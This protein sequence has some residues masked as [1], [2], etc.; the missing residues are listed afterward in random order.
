VTL[1]LFDDV[2]LLDLSLKPA[3]G[4]LQRLA[5]LK[6]YFSQTNYTSQLDQITVRSRNLTDDQT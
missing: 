6:L 4:I 3:K 2:L 1:H 5:L